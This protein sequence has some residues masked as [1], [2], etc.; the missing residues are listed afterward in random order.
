MK[1]LPSQEELNERFSYDKET[2]VLTFKKHNYKSYEGKA[3]GYKQKNGYIVVNYQGKKYRAHRIIWMMMT[4]EDPKELTIDHKD[5]DKSNNAW[6]NL[7]IANHS[8]QQHNKRFRG[9]QK[10]PWGFTARIMVDGRR[11]TL[12][13]FKTQ[14][15]AQSAYEVKCK[16]VRQEF[17]P[18]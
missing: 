4:G 17:A 7:R 15:E 9:C 8:Q 2:G 10:T 5:G 13:T 6:N 1:L 18:Y 3:A 12:G 16:E 14:H 11:L